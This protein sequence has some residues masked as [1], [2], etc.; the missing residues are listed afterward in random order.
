DL[1]AVGLVGFYLIEPPEAGILY[2]SDFSL[3]NDN[4]LIVAQGTF[5]PEKISR[6]LKRPEDNTD[7]VSPVVSHGPRKELTLKIHPRQVIRPIHPLIYGTNL[8][9][10]MEFEKDVVE[11][12]RRSGITQFRFPGGGSEG[13]RFKTGDFDFT[14]LYDDAPLSEIENVIKFVQ[15]AGAELIWQVNIESAT[16]QEAAELVRYLNVEKH[17]PVKYFELGNEVYG[18]WD[19]AFMSGEQYAAVIREFSSAMKAVDP[20]IKIGANYGG[21][22]YVLFDQAVMKNAAEHID[23]VSFHW[24]P[25]HISPEH[26]FDG[27]AHPKAEEIMANAH[28]VE[29]LMRQFD[30]MVRQFAPQREGQIEMMFL[31]WDGSWD[32]KPS[33]IRA[34]YQG[35]MWSLANGIF[36][37]D[38]LGQMASHGVSAASQFNFQEVMFGLIRGW[39]KQAGWGGSRWDGVTVRP[40]ALSFALMANEFK[41]QIIQSELTGSPSYQKENDWRPDAYIGTVPYVNAYVSRRDDEKTI[42]IVLTNKHVSESY[43]V[44]IQLSDVVPEDQG[45]VW[46][47]TGPTLESQND[48]SP[49]VVTTEKYVLE[50]VARE[51]YYKLPSKS[52]NV[53]K[54]KIQ[55]E[56]SNPK[57]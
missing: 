44:N 55:E 24:Y 23:F 12:A 4:S 1:D 33:D 13:Y 15:L 57:G 43:A 46:I 56:G 6:Y 50:D 35:M 47:L 54:I 39:D 10:K 40:K 31:E 27:R 52:V 7:K 36:Y 51:F 11:F 5:D 9:A 38:T 20:Q 3:L 45:Q 28:N 22:S 2:F 41:G 14:D 19:K 26:P 32:A 49:G 18:D 21:P 48:G 30:E 37:A 53:I 16:P 17:Q 8:S 29:T 34:E 42:V 25:N